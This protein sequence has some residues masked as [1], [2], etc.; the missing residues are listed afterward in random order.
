MLEA[1]SVTS[2]FEMA[3][4]FVGVNRSYALL[5]GVGTCKYPQWSLPVTVQDVTAI[6]EV[7]VDPSWGG[8]PNDNEHIRLLCDARATRAGMLE[9][10][11][12]LAAIAD[13][14]PEATIVVY[15]SGH[16]W[17]NPAENSY[18]L[19]TH[20]VDPDRVGASALAGADFIKALQNINSQKLLVIL[21]CCH[22]EGIASVEENGIEYR[23]ADGLNFKPPTGFVPE[24]AKGH[25]STLA[26]G[27]G[28]VILCSSDCH[29]L[30]WIR[31]DR[32]CSV[33]AD[34]LIDA[35]RGA[36]NQAGDSAKPTLREREV[37]VMNL[38]DYLGKTVPET[39][40]AEYRA[41]QQPQAE[42]KGSNNFPIALLCGGKGLPQDKFDEFAALHDRIPTS[43]PIAASERSVTIDRSTRGSTIMP[44]DG[45]IGS[46]KMS[47]MDKD[48]TRIW[49]KKV[50]R[51]TPLGSMQRFENVP[52][53]MQPR[54][55]NKYQCPQCHRTG[56]REDRAD[57]VPI[58]PVHRLPMQ[59]QGD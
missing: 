54:K 21:D 38:I 1:S 40:R 50:E 41:E 32:T 5:I 20:D 6:E 39:V 51:N 19:I 49:Q 15:Y 14:D 13:R 18:Y 7:L 59:S 34:R 10:L 31:K 8:Y 29:Q 43:A 53:E 17:L 58:C 42:F 52:G 55:A 27:K 22:A 4:S 45:N 3:N 47:Q 35:L 16:G 11:Q 28:I 36:G 12:R 30:A 44:D 33:F 26:E 2:R 56:Y 37:T 57:R 24:S 48:K 25:F 23:L 46:E 9:E